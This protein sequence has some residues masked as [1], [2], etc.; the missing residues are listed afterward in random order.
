GNGEFR[1]LS[2]PDEFLKNIQHRIAEKLLAY[3][4]ISPYASAYRPGASPVRNA[5]VHLKGQRILKLDIRHFFDH[6]TYPLVKQKAFPSEKYSESNRILL[7]IICIYKDILPQ[8]APTSPVI[9]N[10]IMR[11]F[12]NAVGEW[13]AQ[14]NIHFTRYCDDMTFSGDFEPREVIDFVRCELKKLGFF[15]NDDKTVTAVCG[16]KKVVTGIVVNEKLNASADYRR[17]IRQ[18]LHYC[19]KYGISAHLEHCGKSQD[20]ETYLRSLL[21][22]INH[23][24]TADPHNSEMKEYKKYISEKL[25][26]H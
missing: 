2:V 21:G 9:S 19:Q 15:L 3:E 12:D 4:E 11:D 24:L 17:K 25:R 14:R 26:K 13:C 18:E 7:S 6:I 20:E 10:I 23:V 16:Q 1:T 8:G 5:A 22:R